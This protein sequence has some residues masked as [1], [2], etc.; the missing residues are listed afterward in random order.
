MSAESFYLLLSYCLAFLSGT[1]CFFFFWSLQASHLHIVD[2]IRNK[3]CLLTLVVFAQY[4]VINLTSFSLIFN[5]SSYAY[6]FYRH[7][8]T[9]SSQLSYY[10]F[11]FACFIFDFFAYLNDLI[12][13]LETFLLF[14]YRFSYNKCC[15]SFRFYYYF[16][17]LHFFLRNSISDSIIYYH[18]NLIHRWLVVLISISLRF[19]FV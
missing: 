8:S 19:Q 7:L 12:F 4:I 14:H 9:V 1:N 3:F 17:L 10:L 15:F 6:Y 2:V 16:F 18:P 11:L 5:N 13:L